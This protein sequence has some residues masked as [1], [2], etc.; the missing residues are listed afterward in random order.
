MI[1]DAIESR[2]NKP[3]ADVDGLRAELETARRQKQEVVSTVPTLPQL[4]L[5]DNLPQG[6][7]DPGSASVVVV[8]KSAHRTHVLQMNKGRVSDVLNVPDATGRE[9]GLTPEGRFQIIYKEK[10]P[11]WYPPAS[12]GGGPVGPGP[13]NP[14][15][16]AELTTNADNGLILLHGTNRPDQIGKNA[17]HGCIRH[18]NPDILKIYSLV[19]PGDSIYI[20][21]QFKGTAIM[22]DDFGHGF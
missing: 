17:S 5:G 4:I 22:T 12:I 6:V 10:N 14:L 18:L 3:V 9:P 19:Q 11:T 1:S 8:D 15:G 7:A 13:D 16:V 20:V 21:P 2:V